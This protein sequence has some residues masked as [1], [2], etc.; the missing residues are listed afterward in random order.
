MESDCRLQSKLV[1]FD[2]LDSVQSCD[3]IKHSSQVQVPRTCFKVATLT[4]SYSYQAYEQPNQVWNETESMDMSFHAYDKSLR[5]Q[6]DSIATYGTWLERNNTDDIK[7]DN[8]RK[9]ERQTLVMP[10]AGLA[11]AWDETLYQTLP[12]ELHVGQMQRYASKAA[13]M[14]VQID[15]SSLVDAQVISPAVNVIC[16]TASEEELAPLIVSKWPIYE[17]K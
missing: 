1:F 13:L 11:N 12:N 10:H 7:D 6:L 3:L 2:A 14:I 16:S 4:T 5:V 8:G 9:F 15:I 17:S